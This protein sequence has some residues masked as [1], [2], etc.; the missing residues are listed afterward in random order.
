MTHPPLMHLLLCTHVMIATLATANTTAA[1]ESLQSTAT[2]QGVEVVQQAQD[3]TVLPTTGTEQIPVVEQEPSSV[4]LQP[5]AGPDRAAEP[6]PPGNCPGMQQ[7]WNTARNFQQ[8]SMPEAAHQTLQRLLND[9]PQVSDRLATVYQARDIL[10]RDVALTM[11][12][13]QLQRID[14]PQPRRQLQT[15]LYQQHME[16]ALES[17]QQGQYSLSSRQLLAQAPQIQQRRDIGM[18]RVLS[19]SLAREGKHSAALQWRQQAA[20]WSGN[21]STDLQ[22]Q[23]WLYINQGDLDNAERLLASANQQQR[24]LIASQRASQAF[25]QQQYQQTLQHLDTAQRWRSREQRDHRIMRAWSLY[26]I[27]SYDQAYQVFSQLYQQ[28]A[29]DDVGKGLFYSASNSDQLLS[30]LLRHGNKG[31]IKTL[32]SD[33]LVRDLRNDVNQQSV[34]DHQ[35]PLAAMV[36]QVRQQLAGQ[37]VE[38]MLSSERANAIEQHARTL[39]RYTLHY[40]DAAMARALS[41]AHSQAADARQDRPRQQHIEQSIAWRQRA[42]DW[43]DANAEDRLAL[44]T[45]YIQQQR[46]DDAEHL[47]QQLVADQPSQGAQRDLLTALYSQRAS[48]AYEQQDYVTALQ[49]LDRL[50]DYRPLQST[51][52]SLSGWAHYRLQEYGDAFDAF[53]QAYDMDEGNPEAASGLMFSAYADNILDDAAELAE[54]HP[55]QLRPLLGYEH[56]FNAARDGVDADYF[57]LQEDGSIVLQPWQRS[58]WI[59]SGGTR[60]SHRSGDSGTSRLTTLRMPEVLLHWRPKYSRH[61]WWS[62]ISVL[63]LS[64][65]DADDEA[66]LGLPQCIFASNEDPCPQRDTDSG[67][68]GPLLEPWLQYRYHGKG[69]ALTVALGTTPMGGEVDAKWTGSFSAAI[70]DESAGLALQLQRR[71]VQESM[72]AYVGIEDPHSSDS[73]GRVLQDSVNI[74]G[75]GELAEQ[76]RALVSLDWANYQGEQV[77]DNRSATLYARMGFI[78]KLRRAQVEVG[79]ELLASYYQ[80]NLS[81]FSQGHGGY[82]SPQMLVRMGARLAWQQPLSRR[83]Y[84]RSQW[85]L[86]YQVH[87]QDCLKAYFANSSR[88]YQDSSDDSGVAAGIDL[89]ILHRLGRSPHH[90]G[91]QFSFNSSPQYNDWSVWLFWQYAT[92]GDSLLQL[93]DT[94]LQ[95][96]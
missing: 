23:I 50:Q 37:Q 82:F 20:Q 91:S 95:L 42:I 9:C 53:A 27:Q 38:A 12:Q 89:A 54:Q 11:A 48:Q 80:H 61:Q 47:L 14:T 59:V 32:A 13:Q 21:A 28:R 7:G 40:R 55:G 84:W 64:S 93:L 86:G 49:Q 60:L 79:P 16:Q 69:A 43:S 57:E 58:D 5:V 15:W 46:T 52:W 2:A 34:P 72:L 87:H 67:N 63:Q 6:L 8:R 66:E 4:P 29:D 77:R 30:A 74:S 45:A 85:T 36:L 44:A 71:P 18:A 33:P 1:D 24:Y 25:A 62:R 22:A 10:G 17:F 31:I 19:D 90:L 41:A 35:P 94:A 75:F 78:P 68:Q 26:H 81:G 56:T 76:S 88:C 39:A 51:E 92:D 65:G 3:V 96:P 83:T 73:W 70:G